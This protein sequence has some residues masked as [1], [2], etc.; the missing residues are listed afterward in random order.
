[1]T[2]YRKALFVTPFAPAPPVEGHRKRMAAT[3]AALHAL[4]YRVDMLFLALEHAWLDL[5]DAAEFR[6]LRDMVDTLHFVRGR[7]PLRLESGTYGI[8]DWWQPEFD[9]Y[10]TWL[11]RNV[12][13]ELVLTNYVFTSRVLLHARPAS[14]RVVDTHDLFADRRAML[15]ARGLRVEFFHTD[16]DNEAA[17]IARA[18]LVLAIKEEEAAVFRD[19]GSAAVV[20]LPYVEPTHQLLATPLRIPPSFGY[21]ASRNQINVRNFLDFV[22]VAAAVAPALDIVAYGSI[23]DALPEDGAG[24]FRRGGRVA[25]PAEFYAAVDCVI[26]PQEFSTGL[27]IKVGEALAFG[28][29]M[30]CHAHAFEGFGAAP[31][32]ALACPDFAAMASWMQRFASEPTLP[33]ELAAAVVA[34]QNRQTAT[35]A[36][37]IAEIGRF[38]AG[39]RSNLL[40][41]VNTAALRHDRLYR[42]VIESVS[43]A[44]GRDWRV[45]LAAPDADASTL[46]ESLLVGGATTFLAP[47]DWTALRDAAQHGFTWRA[48]LALHGGAVPPLGGIP[49]FAAPEIAAYLAAMA[50]TVAP[51]DAAART[52]LTRYSAPSGTPTGALRVAWLR[53]SPW[54]FEPGRDDS[55]ALTSREVWILCRASRRGEARDMAD[56]LGARLGL[57]PRVICANH[58]GPPTDGVAN[59]ATAF[60]EAFGR[61]HAPAGVIDLADGR[62]VFA[63]LREWL[64][65][66]HVPVLSLPSVGDGFELGHGLRAFLTAIAAPHPAWRQRPSQAP[67][68]ANAGWAQVEAACAAQDGVC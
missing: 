39:A 64:A 42:F 31:H 24:R 63:L 3:L 50:G 37:G 43:T 46:D 1:M 28:R 10:A 11:F 61:M 29:P 4:G 35:V 45:V 13:Y 18:D 53:W 5:F 15:E 23:C 7:H 34:V 27:K 52:L 30:I 21:F 65:M 54:F 19:Y 25:D 38:V 2:A 9:D 6:T 32:P 56:S 8:D 26:V 16:R 68:W 47:A 49:V 55:D 59:P 12:S 36:S 60:G 33:D 51:P 57:S 14:V 58:I 66:Q 17:G 67:G 20:T 22:T 41:L 48:A 40:L 62:P 44:F